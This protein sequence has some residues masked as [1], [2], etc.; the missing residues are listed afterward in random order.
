MALG[1]TA[2]IVIGLT[3]FAFQTKYDFTMC[4]GNEKKTLNKV[5]N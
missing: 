5:R 1:L 2:A 3:I 4:G